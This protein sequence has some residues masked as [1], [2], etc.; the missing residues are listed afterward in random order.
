ML[1]GVSVL[2]EGR[3]NAVDHPGQRVESLV[4]QV[5]AMLRLRDERT[6]PISEARVAQLADRLIG[7]SLGAEGDAIGALAVALRNEGIG[8]DILTDCVIPEAARELGRAWEDD[9]LSFVEV[10]LAMTRIQRLLR[11]AVFDGPQDGSG[12]SILFA[13][14]EGEQHTLGGL[15]AVRQL[16]RMRCSACLCIGEKPRRVVELLHAR[17]FDAL[18]VSV[19]TAEGLEIARD[20]IT[21]VRTGYPHE[22]PVV[23]G[24]AVL[25]GTDPTTNDNMRAQTGATFVSNDLAATLR[26]LNLA[27]VH[28][29]PMHLTRSVTA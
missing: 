8:V 14:P 24:G 25:C 6:Q 1:Q 5:I 15:V 13:L 4:G 12:S 21:S 26:A 16:R 20:L 22:L 2:H 19:A 3:T 23:V 29:I 27:P 10:S 18:F 28:L 9:R 11:D 7:A 17:R